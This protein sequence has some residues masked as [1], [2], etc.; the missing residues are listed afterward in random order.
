MRKRALFFLMA[1]SLLC[2]ASAAPVQSDEAM[3]C[4]MVPNANVK[5]YLGGDAVA[6]AMRDGQ[7]KLKEELAST[8]LNDQQK[9]ALG[10]MLKVLDEFGLRGIQLSFAFSEET[11]VPSCCM[12]IQCEKT[13]SIESV[14][15]IIK[16]NDKENRLLFKGVQNGVIPLMMGMAMVSVEASGHLVIVATGADFWLIR[17]NIAAEKC[18]AQLPGVA[19]V[20]MDGPFHAY[21]MR[22]AG[23]D[24][25]MKAIE[26]N[27]AMT[28]AS[29]YV[30]VDKLVIS[31]YEKGGLKILEAEALCQDEE[32][33]KKAFER[34]QKEMASLKDDPRIVFGRKGK[35][36]KALI[37][38]RNIAELRELNQKAAP[39]FQAL[40]KKAVS[41]DAP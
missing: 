41:P 25:F 11:P 3:K 26:E 15:A 38:A 10:E 36:L 2:V 40:K 9:N 1:L 24:N 27:K 21:F 39:F 30:K 18:P 32:E 31:G 4:A 35:S 13:V 34:I 8:K 28:T 17:Q 5:F 12:A 14:A 29:K 22:S 23:L 7:A 19:D 16:R 37:K 33:A 6:K 20:K